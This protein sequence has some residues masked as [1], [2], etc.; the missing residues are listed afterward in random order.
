VEL[1]KVDDTDG[2]T[3]EGA[4]FKIVDHNG[5]DVRSDLTTDKDGKVSV[6]DL[7]PGDYQFIETKAP[8]HYDLNQNPIKFTV[9]KSQTTKAS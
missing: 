4:I 6:S 9:E 5:L 7:H 8:K 3:L 2:S 1:T